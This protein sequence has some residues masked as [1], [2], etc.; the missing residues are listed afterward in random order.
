LAHELAYKL[1]QG[2]DLLQ[3]SPEHAVIKGN[4]QK[5]NDAAVPDH[6]WLQ[7]FAMG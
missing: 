6:L 1:A 5:A 7:A 3:D 4:H 2:L